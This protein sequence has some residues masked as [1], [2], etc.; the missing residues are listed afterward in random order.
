MIETETFEPEI[1]EAEL[2]PAEV[3]E[4]R[5]EMQS[6]IAEAVALGV[7]TGKEAQDWEDGFEACDKLEYMENLLDIIERFVQSGL[8]VLE[9]ISDTLNTPLLNDKEKCDWQNQAEGSSYEGKLDLVNKLST[10]LREVSQLKEKLSKLL[11]N[12]LMRGSVAQEFD[13]KFVEADSSVKEGVLTRA[14]LA[15]TEIATESRQ[16]TSH[17]HS[18][19]DTR[20]F[21]A[22]RQALWV[23]A[24][25]ILTDTERSRLV[26]EIDRAEIVHVR[27]SFKAAA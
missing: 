27:E 21:E 6:K 14:A 24:M 4:L 10:I 12:P 18:L 1:V 25:N 13:K 20:Q 2:L 5:N 19:I 26:S 7:F 16:V 11:A 3:A 23:T 22:A 8:A 17:V 15:A 9:Q